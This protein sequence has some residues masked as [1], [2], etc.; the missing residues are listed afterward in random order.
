LRRGSTFGNGM[1]FDQ[2]KLGNLKNIK[3]GEESKKEG[4]DSV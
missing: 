1:N 2:L 4:N 3:E